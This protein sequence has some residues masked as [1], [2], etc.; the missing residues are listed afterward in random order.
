VTTLD[1]SPAAR[2]SAVRPPADIP[3]AAGAAVGRYR[4]ERL[5]GHGGM[6]WVYLA[7]DPMLRRPVALK[8]ARPSA[9]CSAR[10]VAETRALAQVRHPNV[11]E[12]FDAG[13]HEGRPFLVMECV[14]GASLQQWWTPAR[15]QREVVAAYAQAAQGIAAAHAAGLVH[16]DIKPANVMLDARGRVRVVDFGLARAMDE[17]DETLPTPCC[18][19]GGD[20]TPTDYA[21]GT[22][23]Y[24][25]PE[26]HD[27]GALDGRADQFSLCSALFEGLFGVRPFRAPTV[28][29][30]CRHKRRGLVQAVPWN[31]IPRRLGR[32][33]RRG[34]QADRTRRFPDMHA[35]LAAVG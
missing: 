12:V 28:R 2:P 33:L 8:I 6:G 10:L 3:W 24:M 17:A 1:E 5:L 30:L 15:S 19:P 13:R 9:E 22:P 4:I 14:G 25:A 31:T 21:I 27:G 20:L 34:L 35:L 18:D 7:R 11:V 29:E 26:Q 32:A 16:R 23:A